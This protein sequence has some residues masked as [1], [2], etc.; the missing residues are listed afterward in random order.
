MSLN[1]TPEVFICIIATGILFFTCSVIYRHYKSNNYS[2]ALYLSLFWLFG[3]IWCFFTTLSYLFL[4]IILR[5]IGI[6]FVTFVV[7]HAVKLVDSVSSN[8][9][10]WKKMGLFFTLFTATLITS[11]NENAVSVEPDIFE[12]QSVMTNGLYKYISLLS[13]G[14]S[15]V[16]MTFY[17][18]KIH[19]KAPKT[20]RKYS[21]LTIIGAC[22]G[23][24][25]AAAIA[26]GINDEIPALLQILI[27]ISSI[28]I[29]YAIVKE[30][31][32]AFILPFKAIRLNVIST[33]TGIPIFNYTWNPDEKHDLSDD[34]LFSGLLHGINLFASQTINRGKI[35]EIVLDNGILMLRSSI[36]YPI[37]CVLTATRS[38][39]VLQQ[40]L[41]NFAFQFFEE[42][43]IYL[44]SEHNLEEFS[45]AV[46]L[47]KKH[48]PFV[49][50]FD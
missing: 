50:K 10:D 23:Y 5:K 45:S 2:H 24:F 33:D 49:P 3:G 43:N 25:M 8:I 44:D 6:L 15:A 27:S 13:P 47:I 28:L 11:F 29:S 48:F 35:R 1:W 21:R 19:S 12:Y 38:S 18:V 14:L 41:D 20:L 42:Y 16:I 37:V 34:A 7:L 36:K 40:A 9:V 26:L 31:R 46:V 39:K 22:M 30:P 4:S 32:L 17:F